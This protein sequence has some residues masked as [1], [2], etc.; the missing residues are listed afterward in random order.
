MISLEEYKFLM[1]KR[2]TK[3]D[4][5][6][7]EYDFDCILE[8]LNEMPNPRSEA[9][10]LFFNNV[11]YH[12]AKNIDELPDY[13]FRS[14]TDLGLSPIALMSE[15]NLNEYSLWELIDMEALNPD[16]YLRS[17]LIH[18]KNI[19]VSFLISY[20]NERS[21][22]LS[23]QFINNI[24]ENEDLYRLVQLLQGVTLE[25]SLKNLKRYIFIGVSHLELDPNY[26]IE[27]CGG[28]RSHI[29][30]NTVLTLK[31]CKDGM[32][33][34][35]VHTPKEELIAWHE[36]AKRHLQQAQADIHWAATQHYKMHNK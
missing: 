32:Q 1:K 5:V 20:F 24:V 34:F 31:P 18:Q 9:K 7:S 12:Y 10:S 3:D 26:E 35:L 23:Q 15:C 33:R 21:S 27:L 8:R 19:P 30:I 2:S 6:L 29:S 11:F 25:S 16:E 22:G 14:L 13:L 17:L 4:L 28:I 36:A